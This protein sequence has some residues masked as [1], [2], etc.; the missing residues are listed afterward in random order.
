MPNPRLSIQILAEKTPAP[1]RRVVKR[2]FLPVSLINWL[3]P[4]LQLRALVANALED[5]LWG[6]FSRYAV[7]DLEALKQTKQADSKEV[8]YAAWALARWYASERDFERAYG[9]LALRR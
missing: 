1:I 5:K 9:N 3:Y 2:F 4:S 7:A 6:G 8:G